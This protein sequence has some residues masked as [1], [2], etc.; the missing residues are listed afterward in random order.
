MIKIR[1]KGSRN[2][3]ISSLNSLFLKSLNNNFNPSLFSKVLLLVS[4]YI[5][6][7]MGNCFGLRDLTSLQRSALLNALIRFKIIVRN[8]TYEID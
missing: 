2:I 7:G 6:P 8:I 4:D 3:L 5:K 1:K